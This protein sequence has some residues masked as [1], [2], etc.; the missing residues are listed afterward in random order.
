M[1]KFRHELKHFINISDYYTVRSRLSQVLSH[2]KFAGEDG[3]Y[4]VTSLYFD[5]IYDKALNEK[6]EG[7]NIDKINEKIAKIRKKC[8]I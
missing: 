2:D 7:I 6:I 5:N 3:T 8:N 1:A 4:K